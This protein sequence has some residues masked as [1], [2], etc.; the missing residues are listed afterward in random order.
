MVSTL[1]AQH[2]DSLIFEKIMEEALIKG[3]S[4]QRLGE[5]CKTIGPRLSGSDQAEKGV[6]WAYSMLKSYG[7]DSVF[8]QPVMVPRWERGKVES[9]FFSSS[10]FSKKIKSGIPANYN[11]EAFEEQKLKPSKSYKIQACALGGSI[12]T[13]G[14]LQGEIIVVHNKNE[15]HEL[16]KNG[17]LKGKIVL[18]NQAFYEGNINTFASYGACV[19]QRYMGAVDL[20]KYGAIAVLVRSMT[21]RC[22][23]H[24]HT[25]SMAYVDSVPKIPAMAVASAVANLLDQMAKEDPLL[26]I[27]M[28]M[29]CKWLPDRMS[30]NTIAQ[31]NGSLFPNKFIA[32]GGH[33]DSWDEGE[34][35]HDD[36]AGCMHAFEA[37]R[38]LKSIGY[39]PRHSLRCVWWINEENGLRGAMEYAKLAKENGEIHVAALESDRG[40]FTPRGFSLDSAAMAFTIPYKK[41]LDAYGIGTLEKGGGGA[42][43]GPLKRNDPNTQLVGFI[44]DSQRYFDIHHAETDVFESVNKRELELGAAAV[45][46]MIYILDQNLD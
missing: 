24:P 4:Y 41:Y 17:K 9:L 31:T 44:P 16:G 13:K 26:K 34:G 19:G 5:L 42:D 18:L 3:E 43:I 38:I 12:G 40:G 15:M 14:V 23:L 8:H 32:F 2:A 22:D 27:S 29:D 6:Y 30:A 37:L 45:A 11:C 36:G 28:Q 21:N 46:I 39:I 1:S 20:A 33:F 35:A 25:G 7:F 10:V